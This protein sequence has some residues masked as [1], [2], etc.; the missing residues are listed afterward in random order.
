MALALASMLAV[1]VT[2]SQAFAA[3]RGPSGANLDRQYYAYAGSC[4]GSNAYCYRSGSQKRSKK[5]H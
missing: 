4:Q 5:K 1:F 3:K 2:D